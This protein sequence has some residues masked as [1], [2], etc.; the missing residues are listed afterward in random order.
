[1]IKPTKSV[2]YIVTA[3][4]SKEGLIKYA[5]KKYEQ[6]QRA[7]REIN[8]R[9]KA[10]GI[11]MYFALLTEIKPDGTFEKFYTL[12]S[13]TGTDGALILASAD[14][15][16]NFVPDVVMNRRKDEFF[17]HPAYEALVNKG[18]AMIN[19]REVAV[20]GDKGI[21]EQ[22][23][24]AYM[25]ETVVL[26]QTGIEARQA[27]IKRSFDQF[28]TIVIKPHRSN[29]GRGVVI[30]SNQNDP[31]I[32]EVAHD[33]EAYVIQ[34]YI[35]T[36]GGIKDLVPG[37]H[38]VRLYVVGGDIVGSSIRQ[39]KEG[40]LL[41]NTSQ[42]GTIAFY[43]VAELPVEL[44]QLGEEILKVLDLP[45]QSFISLDFFYGNGKWYLIEAND[46]PGVPAEYQNKAVASSIQNALVIICKEETL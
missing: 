46:Q 21:S 36:E 31:I 4:P 41:S 34:Q 3:T 27:L 26:D 22:K 28:G 18:V 12:S 29:G 24:S 14:V 8:D 33:H 39:P 45:R 9:Y 1:M 13:K 16:T 40:S 20:L 6:F 2:V 17:T 42:G 37:R 10:V 35:E 11:Q 32:Q 25:P 43:E 38:D 19:S 30:T 23:L 7:F 15:P 44:L 5:G